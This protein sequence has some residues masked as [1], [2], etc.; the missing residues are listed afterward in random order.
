MSSCL[1]LLVLPNA[2]T[3]LHA[4]HALSFLHQLVEA[5]NKLLV[6]LSVPPTILLDK[7]LS[8]L[9][10]LN[11]SCACGGIGDGFGPGFHAKDAARL[12]FDVF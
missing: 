3:S 6:A 9:L 4:V 10:L 1:F 11:S 7:L 5:R 12:Y 2:S 8:V